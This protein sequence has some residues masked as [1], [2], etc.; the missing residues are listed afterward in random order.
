MLPGNGKGW[1]DGSRQT[2]QVVD[3]AGSVLAG[4][5]SAVEAIGTVPEPVLSATTTVRGGVRMVEGTIARCLDAGSVAEDS[6]DRRG[7]ER[8]FH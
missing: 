1:I 6:N 8:L 2:G 5:S 7:E 4:A 3:R